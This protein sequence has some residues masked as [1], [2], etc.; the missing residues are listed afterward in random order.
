MSIVQS[1]GGRFEHC[2]KSGGGG[3]FEHN[4]ENPYVLGGSPGRWRVAQL[5]PRHGGSA[6]RTGKY[7]GGAMYEAS[8]VSNYRQVERLTGLKIDLIKWL[9][10]GCDDWFRERMSRPDLPPFSMRAL[11]NT[12]F[13]GEC[14]QDLA[15]DDTD[16]TISL[17][18]ELLEYI[19]QLVLENAEVDMTPSMRRGRKAYA[20]GDDPTWLSFPNRARKKYNTRLG[21]DAFRNEMAMRHGLDTFLDGDAQCTLCHKSKKVKE[22]YIS[23]RKGHHA[24]I[25]P[26]LKYRIARHDNVS[27]DIGDNS[28]SAG[29]AVIYEPRIRGVKKR[30]GDGLIDPSPCHRGTSV[31]WDTVISN[32]LCKSHRH[33]L[34]SHGRGELEFRKQNQKHKHWPRS[35][36]PSV[37]KLAVS[38]G[39]TGAAAPEAIKLAK[40]I[41]KTLRA[42]LG[43]RRAK[44][45]V[46]MRI[47]WQYSIIKGNSQAIEAHKQAR[48]AADEKELAQN[49]ELAKSML[50]MNHAKQNIDTTI[51]KALEADADIVVSELSCK[52]CAA[53]DSL[54]DECSVKFEPPCYIRP[55][56]PSSSSTVSTP[57]SCRSSHH[58]PNSLSVKFP[59]LSIEDSNEY[60]HLQNRK[61]V[62]LDIVA[63]CRFKSPVRLNDSSKLT[64]P[65]PTLAGVSDSPVEEKLSETLPSIVSPAK[66]IPPTKPQGI[67]P[68]IPSDDPG[69]SQKSIRSPSVSSTC[70]TACRGAQQSHHASAILSVSGQSVSTLEHQRS[71][72]E[73]ADEETAA[74]RLSAETT[75]SVSSDD[76]TEL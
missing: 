8:L 57:N 73:L 45:L 54:C 7:V 47:R 41:D 42:R 1:P 74:M 53:S 67:P 20:S 52:R 63:R 65:A 15:T 76:E 17:D 6:L 29:L 71:M 36:D 31:M 14:N 51:A 11:V 37:A 32:P 61:M 2:P 26:G 34:D 49:R 25:C 56:I 38:L 13:S 30:R 10:D 5:A 64:S 33:L 44:R 69:G 39:T 18:I 19:E 3:R 66:I 27:H 75:N 16:D 40:A 43:S 22:L 21:N 46:P 55:T 60:P 48:Y 62:A 68:D 9:E 70:E 58:T 28:T 72:A 50:E 4:V 59:N 23:D 12:F 24:T 35:R